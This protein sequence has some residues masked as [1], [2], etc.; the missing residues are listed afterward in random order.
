M[1][2]EQIIFALLF[3]LFP[4][5]ASVLA[6]SFARSTKIEMLKLEIRMRENIAALRD[7]LASRDDLAE[8][9]KRIERLEGLAWA[10][11]KTR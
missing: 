1:T 10:G 2:V 8:A 9:Q 3:Q 5:I 6:A 4:A 7:E 11:R